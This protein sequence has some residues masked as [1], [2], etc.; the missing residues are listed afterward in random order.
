VAVSPDQCRVAAIAGDQ[1]ILCDLETGAVLT[2]AA[3]TN[4][5]AVAKTGFSTVAFSPDGRRLA[6]GGEDGTAVFLDAVTLQPLTAPK[7]LHAGQVAD[8]AYASGGAVLVTGGGYE[9]G[10]TLTDVASGQLITNF[11]AVAEGFY[12]LQ[13]LAVS[14]DGKQLATGSP[15]R[16]IRLWDLGTRQLLA[17][18]PQK[19]RFPACMTFSPDG[20][21]LAFA[22][23]LGSLYLW[24]TT[25]RRQLRARSGHSGGVS[26]LAFSPDGTLA[27][28]GMDHTIRL[29]HPELDQEAVILTGHSGWIL[30]LAFAEHGNALVSGSFDGTLRVWRALSVEQIEAQERAGVVS[31]LK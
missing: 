23:L 29:W 31:R 6:V 25:G 27:S 7:N 26:A 1:L 20:R 2:R 10:I 13:P 9:T 30:C 4:V 5:F 19:M 21:L 3:A 24:D 14:P 18:C 11:R 15:D 8:I 17:T 12:P 16:L 28:G 22:D